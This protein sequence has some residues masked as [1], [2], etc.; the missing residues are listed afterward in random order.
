M[1]RLIG[2]L[3][4]TTVWALP[5]CAQQAPRVAVT[6]LAYTQAVAQYFEV[7]TEKSSSNVRAGM[8]S[9]SATAQS[10]GT[11]VA[12]SYSYVEQRELGSFTNDIKGALLRGTTF[13]LVQGKPFDSGSPQPSK[14]EQVLNQVQTGK[15]AAQVK[16]PQVHDIV[17]RIRKGEFNGAEYVLFGTLTSL[18]FRDTVSSLQGTTSASHVYSLDLVAD[19][20]LISTKTFEIKAA[21]SAQGAGSDIKLLNNRVELLPPNRGKV[22]RETSQSLAKSV[23]EQLTEQLQIVGGSGAVVRSGA[24]VQMGVSPS[25]A[26]ASTAQEGVVILR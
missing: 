18:Q 13:R 26:P 8:Y 16:Q 17:S 7:A 9:M 11:Y 20:S 4:A 25:G 10:Q 6:D 12:G 14:A 22:M 21:F 15:V 2:A 23:F 1:R 5:V 24:P 3:A 19:F